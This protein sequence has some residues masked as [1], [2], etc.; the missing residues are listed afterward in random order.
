MSKQLSD[1]HVVISSTSEHADE[2]KF[3]YPISAYRSDPSTVCST[4]SCLPLGRILC[5]NLRLAGQLRIVEIS[6]PSPTIVRAYQ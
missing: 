6:D 1:F 4:L 3:L 5:T 2:I